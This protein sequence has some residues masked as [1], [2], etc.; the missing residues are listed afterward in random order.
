MLLEADF[1]VAVSVLVFFLIA[2]KFGLGKL[3]TGSLDARTKQIAG[4][5][6]EAR[7]FR[8]EADAL[9][10]AYE[11]K[12]AAAEREAQEIVDNARADAERAAADA[13][14]RLTEFVARR[15]A[16]AEAKIAQAETQAT[17]EV[18]AAAA[19]AAVRAAGEVLRENLKSG[20]TADRIFADSLNEVRTQIH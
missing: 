11:A 3:V 4:D 18:R 15:T 6:A 16:A 2:F 7:R 5:L 14:A 17:A 12:R 8:D 13:H 19:E 9:L 20:K 1:W 10:K